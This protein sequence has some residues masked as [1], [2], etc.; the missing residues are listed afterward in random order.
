VAHITEDQ[1]KALR[2]IK[3]AFLNKDEEVIKQINSIVGTPNVIE[4]KGELLKAYD[5]LG[6]NPID[7]PKLLYKESIDDESIFEDM[8]VVFEVTGINPDEYEMSD[9]S[10]FVKKCFEKVNSLKDDD[11]NYKKTERTK[12]AKLPKWSDLKTI[13]KTLRPL[14]KLN[15]EELNKINATIN[16][17][18]P[19]IDDDEDLKEALD[20]LKD[21][22]NEQRKPFESKKWKMVQ[23]ITGI[24]ISELTEW[25]KTL[26]FN[27]NIMAYINKELNT[28]S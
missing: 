21:H 28:P 17:F 11:G 2:F 25:E 15:H 22:Y 7:E 14:D 27:A 13:N 5:K 20:D 3:Q 23:K 1:K 12:D 6:S 16:G 24:K 9:V 8:D 26:L 18:D 4:L 10:A 19:D